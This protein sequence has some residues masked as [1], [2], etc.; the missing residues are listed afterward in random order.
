MRSPA[1]IAFRLKQ[2]AANR[3]LAV[4]QPQLT[5]SP[6]PAPLPQLPDPHHI[7]A[8]LQGTPLAGQIISLADAACRGH[9]T[10]FDTVIEAGPVI[11]W[12]RDYRHGVTTPARYFRQIPYLDFTRAGDHKQIWE[13]NR[14]QHFVVLAQAWLFT[15][16]QR[17][18]KALQDQW[19]SWFAQN[20][21]H[22]GINWTSALEVAFRALSWIWTYH[23][24]GAALERSLVGHFWTHLHQHALHLEYNLSIYFSPNTHLLGEAVALHAI[25][26]LFPQLPRAAHWRRLGRRITLQQL[27]FQVAE[28]GSH[29]EQSTYYHVYAVDF[30]A[31]HHIL[32]PLPAGGQRKL[33]QMAC[34]LE[35]ILGPE[36]RLPVFGDDDGGRLF[37]P[38]GSRQTFGR[39]TL[40][41][42]SLLFPDQGFPY[43][44]EDLAEQSQWWLGAK[45]GA[46]PAPPPR[47]VPSQRFPSSGLTVLSAGEIHIVADTGPFGFGGAG[48]S[49]SDGLSVV[50]RRGAEDVLIDPGTFDYVSDPVW[51]NRFRGSAMHNTIRVNGL[52][53][54]LP[55]GSFR[56]QNKANPT[57]LDWV[58]TAGYDYL[59]AQCQGHRRRLLFDKP[60]QLLLILD[61]V[62]GGQAEIFWHL[63][64]AGA[65]LRFQSTIQLNY[66]EGGEYGWRSPVFGA[67]ECA[68][69]LCAHFDAGSLQGIGTLIDLT[70]DPAPLP[71]ELQERQGVRWLCSGPYRYAFP[72]RGQ[73]QW[74]L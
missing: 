72:E 28:D 32:E 68:S 17:Y 58:T 10:I 26:V 20:P 39:A 15:Q 12:R 25:G 36:R 46:R 24:A 70:E 33:Q 71:L 16:D 29:F 62:A 13:L 57:L 21:F 8:Q 3:I 63:G 66:M 11:D 1:E 53:Q 19:E 69:V 37:H 38:Y 42:C 52:D 9:L 30:F 74:E 61:T 27:D 48:H 49:H 2:L 5:S 65:A 18:L 35:A 59:D 43:Q 67:R 44:P 73:P 51:R 31:L 50:V 34:F 56:W 55:A 40:A 54:A 22:Y 6:P 4:T 14:Q 47:P 41:T 23:F 64:H 7:A 45:A 60:R